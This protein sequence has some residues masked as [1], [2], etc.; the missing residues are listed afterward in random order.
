MKIVDVNVLLYASIT[1]LTYHRE[2]QRWL[3]RSLAG[4]E[5]IGLPWHTI[6]GYLRIITSPQATKTPVTPAEAIVAAEA[7]LSSPVAVV[8]EPGPGHLARMG[9]LLAVV[10]TGG[11]A[12]PDAHLAALAIQHRAT[13]VSFDRD[14]EQVPGLRWEIPR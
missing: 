9:E 3:D 14:F 4:S 5:A 2:A 6:L 10:G 11:K 7:W 13:L 1:S 12:V 8:P